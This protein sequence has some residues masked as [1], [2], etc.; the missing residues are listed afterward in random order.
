MIF[1]SFESQ[2]ATSYIVINSNIDSI[3]LFSH[4]L[5]IIHPLLT[6]DNGRTDGRQPYQRR[7]QHSYFT[8]LF[9]KWKCRVCMVHR[10]YHTNQNF[11]LVTIAG[12][13][14]TWDA[15]QR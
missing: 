7:L 15:R 5:A 6:N 11:C 1:M 13:T 9:N 2:Y 3:L 4:H 8:E 12:F 10:V 14:M